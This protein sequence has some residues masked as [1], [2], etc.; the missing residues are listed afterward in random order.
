[1]FLYVLDYAP[2]SHAVGTMVV[3]LLNVQEWAFLSDL[4]MRGVKEAMDYKEVRADRT[5]WSRDAPQ[6]YGN[7][8]SSTPPLYPPPPPAE[9]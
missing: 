6:K 1:M 3:Y 7:T 5:R 4:D 9:F 2:K 8:P